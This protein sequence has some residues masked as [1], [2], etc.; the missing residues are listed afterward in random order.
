MVFRGKVGFRKVLSLLPYALARNSYVRGRSG[1]SQ[2]EA[3]SRNLSSNWPCS[4]TT[5]K[6]PERGRSFTR[7]E[8][9]AV[10]GTEITPLLGATWN[11]AASCSV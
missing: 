6:L 3:V 1:S 7:N 11:S 5:T 2:P 10:A 8:T 9:C 4:G